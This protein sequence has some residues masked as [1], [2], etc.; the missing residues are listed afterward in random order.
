V[1]EAFSRFA[2]QWV[3]Y[4]TELDRVLTERHRYDEMT[5]LYTDKLAS[6]W[7]EDSTTEATRARIEEKIDSF[8]EGDLEHATE[9]L[10]TLWEIVNT[11][12]ET[13]APPG[14]SPAVS[15][16]LLWHTPHIIQECLPRTTRLHRPRNPP[17]GPLWKSLSSSQ[18]ARES[19]LTGSTGL[20]TR[21]PGIS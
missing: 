3:W 19:F 20:G 6:V 12:G 2:S 15:R 18:S 13:T 14:N 8:Y 7:M 4:I 11:D 1:E 5:N 10:S 17:N 9:V 16:F 21:R